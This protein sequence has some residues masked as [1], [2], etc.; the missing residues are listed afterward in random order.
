MGGWV[1]ISIHGMD[2]IIYTWH[3]NFLSRYMKGYIYC[4]HTTVEMDFEKAWKE[5]MDMYVSKVFPHL[6][7]NGMTLST[8]LRI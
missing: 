8:I 1:C 2:L 4:F 6:Y 5:S 3:S 7:K